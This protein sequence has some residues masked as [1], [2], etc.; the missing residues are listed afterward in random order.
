MLPRPCPRFDVP[1]LVD[2]FQQV[3]DRNPI[4]RSAFVWER[5]DKPMQVV[6]ERVKLPF[7]VVDLRVLRPLDDAATRW[8]RRLRPPP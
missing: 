5:L 8:A 4:L 2:C 3:V 1:A 7:E 6:R